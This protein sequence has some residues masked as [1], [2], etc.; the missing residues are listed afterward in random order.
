MGIRSQ[1][2]QPGQEALAFY[3]ELA[4]GIIK[5]LQKHHMTIMNHHNYPSAFQS[6]ITLSFGI[7]F[8]FSGF[9]HRMITGVM[10][11]QL[12]SDFSIGATSL[13]NFASFYY[14]SYVAVQIPTGV[15]A[16]KLGPRKLLTVGTLLSSIGTLIFASASSIYVANL[17]RLI[18]GA[19]MGVAWVSILKLTT[20]WFRI[21][22]F[23]VVTGIGLCLGFLGA[24]AAGAPLRIMMNLLG[25]RLIMLFVAIAT[26]ALSLAIWLYLRDDPSQKGYDSFLTNINDLTLAPRT[27]ILHNLLS[28]FKFKNT[29]VLSIASA[30]LIGP[31]LTFAGLWGIP[32]IEAQYDINTVTS[33]TIVATLLL[34]FAIGAPFLGMLSEKNGCRKT[35]YFVSMCISLCC[36]IPIIY[37][38]MPLWLLVVMLSFEGFASSSVVIGMAFVKESVPLSLAGT[39]SGVSNMG[40][41]MGP[42]ILQPAIGLLLGLE[43]EGILINGAYV[44]S[45]RAYHIALSLLIGLA[46]FGP[47]L[48][49]FS[50]E[51]FCRQSDE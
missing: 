39:V 50:K 1:A 35:I 12:M 30:C 23:A 8:Y 28:V 11:D 51:T 6:W 45:I 22:Q 41:E 37:I 25:W 7:A 42:M 36:W 27:S 24:L 5:F 46:V 47:L 2:G 31:I 29:W 40:M 14:Y 49:L 10:A 48:I 33:A 38:K 15:L 3:W 34:S 44:Y 18:I 26:F 9:F 4:R 21:N 20:R 17:G 16:D 43:W 19:S 32:Y 13:G